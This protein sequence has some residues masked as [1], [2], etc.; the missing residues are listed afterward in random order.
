MNIEIA[1][2]LLPNADLL[3]VFHRSHEIY[4]VLSRAV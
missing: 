1:T 2:F 3:N 4:S